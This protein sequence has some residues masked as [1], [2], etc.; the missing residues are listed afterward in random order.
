MKS[1]KLMKILL[2]V[3]AVIFFTGVIQLQVANAGKVKCWNDD[4]IGGYCAQFSCFPCPWDKLC[5]CRN[6]QGNLFDSNCCECGCAT[7]PM[8]R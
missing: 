4:G 3:A 7:A 8:P 2:I 1:R 6:A 5:Q